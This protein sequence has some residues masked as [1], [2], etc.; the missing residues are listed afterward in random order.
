MKNREIINLYNGIIEV[1][2]K[3]H[4]GFEF[5]YA[6]SRNLRKLEPI[7]KS[8]EEQ[9][10]IS[11]EFKKF[12]KEQATLINK[13]GNWNELLKKFTLSP[14]NEK[15]FRSEMEKLRSKYKKTI[16]DQEEKSIEYNS[17]LEKELNEKVDFH[18]INKDNIPKTLKTNEI[19]LIFEL[20]KY[21]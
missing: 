3:E 18:L 17:Y 10:K 20:I 8:I 1:Q 2:K 21:E 12:E 11:E 14:E 13:Y 19:E 5:G 15:L 4:E 7:I 6:L 9:H 16:E